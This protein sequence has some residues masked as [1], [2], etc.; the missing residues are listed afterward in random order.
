MLT[1]KSVVSAEQAVSYGAIIDD[2]LA[3]SDLASVSAKQVRKQL[4]EKLGYDIT[5]QKVSKRIS[6][7]G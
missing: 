7:G 6:V 3:H 1:Q 5:D 4:A 2:I